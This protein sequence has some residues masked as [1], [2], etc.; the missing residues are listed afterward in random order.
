MARKRKYIWY[1]EP[2]GDVA[3]SNEIIAKNI[4]NP[5]VGSQDMLCADGKRHNLWRCLSA[6]IFKIDSSRANFGEKF[7]IRIFCQEGNGQIRN[8]TKWYRIKKGRPSYAK[9]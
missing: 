8:V 7:R 5:E 6:E 4:R 3:Y 2:L 1:L 9:F